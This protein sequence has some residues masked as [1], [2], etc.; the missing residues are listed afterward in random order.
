MVN[1]KLIATFLSTN[2][3]FFFKLFVDLKLKRY[4][5]LVLTKNLMVIIQSASQIRSLK[6]SW[7]VLILYA[8][9]AKLTRKLIPGCCPMWRNSTLMNSIFCVLNV[10]KDFSPGVAG[11][12]IWKVMMKM[13]LPCSFQGCDKVFHSKANLKQHEAACKKNPNRK[14]NELFCPHCGKRWNVYTE[15]APRTQERHPWLSL[16]TT[17][18]ILELRISSVLLCMCLY[19]LRVTPCCLR[20]YGVFL[21]TVVGFCLRIISVRFCICAPCMCPCKPPYLLRIGPYEF[22]TRY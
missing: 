10:I 22:R 1:S 4:I 13:H 8:Q 11:R 5:K 20:I 19:K 14:G 18:T 12:A 9:G 7:R 6:R 3:V 2:V 15:Q 16:T 17:T 21:E